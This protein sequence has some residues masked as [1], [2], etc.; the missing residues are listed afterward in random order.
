MSTAEQIILEEDQIVTPV[1]EN[2]LITDEM[3]VDKPVVKPVS[4]SVLDQQH[5]NS[6]SM[7]QTDGAAYESNRKLSSSD[8]D[9]ST[10]NK[11][12]GPPG[13]GLHN[14]ILQA[15]RQERTCYGRELWDCLTVMEMSSKSRTRQMEFTK[16]LLSAVK[17]GFE[18]FSSHIT[19]ATQIYQRKQEQ[20]WI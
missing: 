7:E 17:K 16:D 1:V 12:G 20:L 8:A 10:S 3:E 15:N 6:Q 19:H 18:N 14:G 11:S 13:S 2:L 4:G 9:S 5:S